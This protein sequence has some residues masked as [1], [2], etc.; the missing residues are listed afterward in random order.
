VT[1]TGTNFSSVSATD[2]V[3][4]NGVTATVTQASSTQL[5]V[6]VPAGASSGKITVNVSGKIATSTNSFIVL[7]GSWL[8]K[9]DFGGGGRDRA[10]GFTIGNEGYVIGGNS[11]I[12]NTD[13][14]DFWEYDSA[15]NAWTKKAD[16]PGGAREY[17]VAFSIGNKGYVG[18]GF[19][20][21]APTISS[22]TIFGNMILPVINGL[23]KIMF[24]SQ[25]GKLL[26]VL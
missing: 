3:Q 10:V 11:R 19:G 16:F 14:T 18:L 26:S 12:T 20:S 4:F 21:A 7:T 8:Q 15:S 9:A 6:T 1:I 22:T 2:I 25:E 5:T 23:K 17:A 24:R 13:A